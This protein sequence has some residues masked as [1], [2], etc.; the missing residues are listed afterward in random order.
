[1]FMNFM[2]NKIADAFKRVKKDM[3]SLEEKVNKLT[4]N[5]EFMVKELM[6]L[7]EAFNISQTER[8]A[9]KTVKKVSRKTKK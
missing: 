9:E 4:A 2:E 8:V 1:M 3:G 5:Q 7:K 6:R